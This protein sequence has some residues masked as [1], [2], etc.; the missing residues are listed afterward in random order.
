IN[1]M[2]RR[3]RRRRGKADSNNELLVLTSLIF[4]IVLSGGAS[5]LIS[6]AAV[7]TI[8][9][10]LLVIV[11]IAFSFAIVTIYVHK[12]RQLKKL[13]ALELTR[14]IDPMSGAEF[15]GY[16][17]ALLH[18]RGYK[19]RQVGKSGDLGADIIATYKGVRMVVQV[20]RS[21]HPISRRAVS[22]A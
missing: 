13:K 9:A 6:D 8:V 1:Y 7:H 22:D 18:M 16:V 21:S 20:K 11:T 10:V 15:E 3:Y 12:Q 17:A 14:D 4:L 19:A 2:P 5:T